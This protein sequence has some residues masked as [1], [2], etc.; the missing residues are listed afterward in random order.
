MSKPRQLSTF[1]ATMLVMG[2]MIGVGIF[3]TP[4][5]VAESL[6]SP[7]LFIGAWAFG[8]IVAMCGAFTF[9]ELGTSYP[10]NG[11]WFIFLREAFGKF[12]AFLFAWTILGVTTT[13]AVAV[14]CDFASSTL[15]G[16]FVD[17]TGAVPR[18][19]LAAV[20]IAALNGLAF[21]GLRVGA[22]FQN[23][24]MITKLIAI[25]ALLVGAVAFALPAPNSVVATP[26]VTTQSVDWTFA[27]LA[28]GV[29]PILFSY[30]GWQ[31]VCYI[32]PSVRKPERTLPVAILLGTAAVGVVYIASNATFLHALGI[33]GLAAD[34]SF[35]TTL[36]RDSIGIGFERALR[37]AMAVSAIGVALVTILV[38]PDLYVATAKSGLFFRSFERRHAV[39]N[40]P[41]LAIASQM[42]L[43]LG[44]LVWAH[45][46]T[47]FSLPP[48]ADRMNPDTL[49]NAL[50][51]AEWI[52]HGLA[53]AAL[54]RLRSRRT[55]LARPFHMP[56]WPLPT[57]VYLATAC[58]IVA[59]NLYS[60]SARPEL[61]VGVLTA[62]AIAYFVW[63]RGLAA[64]R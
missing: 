13:A 28:A 1:D 21:A 10:E 14:I 22:R 49:L 6:Q 60:G 17:T 19:V 41:I 63:T 62:G 8:A 31:N 32:A 7:A 23:F 58:F 29:L 48:D 5:R 39:T 55:G 25:A 35:A 34:R 16:L 30:G 37:A 53:A 3:F 18:I 40:A 15:L 54:L 26:P 61:G 45:A 46:E 64:R 12:A 33:D 50:V 59:V 44:Y 57:L 2:G 43:A 51:F 52:F 4:S 9:A 47:I 56:L 36:A 24:C 38:C 42:I 27:A 11:G 20:I